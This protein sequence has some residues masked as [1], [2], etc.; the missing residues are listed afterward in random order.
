MV[1]YGTKVEQGQPG[2]EHTREGDRFTVSLAANFKRGGSTAVD[3]RA[4]SDAV[5]APFCLARA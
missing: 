1:L 3:K 4:P 2:N 5:S